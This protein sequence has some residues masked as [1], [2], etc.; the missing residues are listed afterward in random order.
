MISNRKGIAL[1]FCIIIISLLTH[2]TLAQEQL[3][4]PPFPSHLIH[5]SATIEGTQVADNEMVSAKLDRL[6]IIFMDSF[7]SQGKINNIINDLN[8]QSAASLSV[9]VNAL[10]YCIDEGIT[11]PADANVADIDT[12]TWQLT[13][14]GRVY[15]IVVEN[16]DVWN[17]AAWINGKKLEVFLHNGVIDRYIMGSYD[18]NEYILEIPLSSDKVLVGTIGNQYLLREPLK[19]IPG[20]KVSFYIR[21]VRTNNVNGEDVIPGTTLHEVT[22]KP[23]VN[24]NIEAPNEIP[25]SIDL[26]AGWNLI[27]IPVWLTNTNRDAVLDTILDSY[28]S[29]WQYIPSPVNDWLTYNNI[30]K[31]GL[32][33]TVQS[34]I[35]YWIEM[36][37]DDTLT[38]LGLPIENGN[39]DLPAGWSL[40]GFNSLKSISYEDAL[41]SVF[42][43]YNSIWTYIPFPVN[44]WISYEKGEDYPDLDVTPGFG[45]W[46]EMD[47]EDTWEIQWQMSE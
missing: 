45:Y 36:E 21:G 1:F 14:G 22:E 12:N 33:D 24:V 34:G 17:G 37:N 19:A 41:N 30:D 3:T 20:D 6:L 25:F 47:Q 9:E 29:I 26:K 31:D 23:I 4:P 43:S 27:S 2:V 39:I 5:G 16:I 8:I 7:D 46:F 38:V 44:D 42:N 18:T 40:V 35:G 32:L 10:Q 15:T 13:G 28:I 11:L